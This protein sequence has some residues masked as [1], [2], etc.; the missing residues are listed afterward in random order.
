[1]PLSVGDRLGP[2]E[3]G[4]PIGAGGMGEVYKARDTRLESSR[5]RFPASSFR[6]RR[7]GQAV[8]SSATQIAFQ[9]ALSL[10]AHERSFLPSEGYAHTRDNERT[11]TVGMSW[12]GVVV[13][14]SVSRLNIWIR[15]KLRY[16]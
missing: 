7:R 9:T 15:D 6:N 8:F 3:I 12:A 1:M 14:T 16:V 5:S 11:G 10:T 13:S 2:Y 4:A